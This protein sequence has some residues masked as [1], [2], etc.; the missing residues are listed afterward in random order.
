MRIGNLLLNNAVIAAPMAGVSDRPYRA[1]ARK[2]GASMAVSEMLTAQPHL[3]STTKTRYRMDIH[4]E[5]PPVSVQLVGTEPQLLADAAR[6]NVDNGAD[7]IDINMGCPAKKVCKKLAGSALLGDE[8]LVAE[9]LAA[10]VSSVD[11]PVTLKIRTGLTPDVRN[12]INIAHIAEDSGIQALTIHG[13]TRQCRFVGEVEYDTISEVKEAISIPV[14]ANGDID[15]PEKAL[16]VLRSTR[17]DAVMIGRAAQGRPW[18]FGQVVTF[19]ETGKRQMEPSDQEKVTIIL[20]HVAAIHAFYG[21]RLG[22]KLAR[23]HIAWYLN[24]LPVDLSVERAE[25]NRQLTIQKQYQLLDSALNQF[26]SARSVNQL[27]AQQPAA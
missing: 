13:R 23:K 10:V 27:I 11:V 2:M 25:I 4:E 7:I 16:T 15:S 20:E 3:R 1:L 19:L 6:F 22:V 8:A 26:L 18:L 14:I 9:I 12:A 5:E 17:A 24:Y 21:E